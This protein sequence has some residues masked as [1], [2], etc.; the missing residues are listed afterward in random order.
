MLTIYV[1]KFF[2]TFEY[3]TF[4]HFYYNSNKTVILQRYTYRDEKN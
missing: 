4:L 1:K 2:K 3:S